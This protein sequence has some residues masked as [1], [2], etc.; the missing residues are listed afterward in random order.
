LALIDATLDLSR[1]DSKR[2][3]LDIRPL[4]VPALLRD[5]AAEIAH[6]TSKP[7]VRVR[8]EIDPGLRSLA[9]DSAKL[10]VI[11]KNLIDNAMK[12]TDAGEVRIG[13][14]RH[15][16]GVELSVADTGIGIAPDALPIIFEAFRQADGS[17]TR[18]HGGI[19]LG[20]HLVRRLL[21]LMGGTIEVESA[22]GAG[23]TFR[24]LLPGEPS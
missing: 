19:G 12:F 16:G 3:P 8:W 11:L 15:A 5:V 13:V 20:L 9:A 1:L 10:K 17:M 21:D 14:R 18:R 22:P 24:V 6:V 4:D 7:G 23:S 2:L